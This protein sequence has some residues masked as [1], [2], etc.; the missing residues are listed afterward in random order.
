MKLPDGEVI[1]VAVKAPKIN[2]LTGTSA[3]IDDF[4]KEAKTTLFFNH[5]NV[6]KCL[7][8]SKEL[9]ELPCLLFEY[10]S[11]GSLEVVLA[12]NRTRN[13]VNQQQI[14]LTNVSSYF[15]LN[16][17]EFELLI[18][19]LFQYDLQSF[20]LDIAKGM[21]YLASQRFVHRDLAT[22]N[23]LVNSNKT[24]KISDFGMTRTLTGSSDYYVSW[25]YFKYLRQLVVAQFTGPMLYIFDRKDP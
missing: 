1:D 23:C 3:A 9:D 12:S 8:F 2:L 15:I 24:V 21:A 14:K 4:Y 5:E 25:Q 7:G 6:V 18:S 13:F 10:M 22:R 19:L 16:D 11:Y 17:F 20:S